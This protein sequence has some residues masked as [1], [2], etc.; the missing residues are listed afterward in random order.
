ML[1]R[2]S[3]CAC[4]SGRR[5]SVTLDFFFEFHIRILKVICWR[6]KKKFGGLEM[7]GPYLLKTYTFIY[8]HSVNLSVCFDFSPNPWLT[9]LKCFSWFKSF[10]QESFRNCIKKFTPNL[11]F[12][13]H[14]SSSEK[15]YF[16][17][18]RWNQQQARLFLYFIHI[19]SN[20]NPTHTL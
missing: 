10:Y 1:L 14:I 7:T 9:C 8:F 5:R 3:F 20:F 13:N 6:S 15:L 12:D 18:L 11:S 2:A 4:Q 16:F 17:Q 19:F